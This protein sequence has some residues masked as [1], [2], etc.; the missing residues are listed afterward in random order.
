[1]VIRRAFFVWQFAAA[2]VLPLWV[3]LGYALWGGGAGGLV[4]VTLLTPL[5]VIAQLGLAALLSARASV[6]RAR[7]L[8]W[9]DVAVIAVLSLA[10]V[11]LGFFGPAMTWFA[12]LAVA[13]VLGGYWL[14]IAELVTEVRTR[15]RATLASL[16]YE[17]QPAH[18]PIDAGEYIVIKPAEQPVQQPNERPTQR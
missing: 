15:M 2:V 13:A 12:V 14:A 17:P 3:L 1:M 6:R 18:T 11:G 9:A 5:L 10:V 4:A 8:G 7:A 16:G